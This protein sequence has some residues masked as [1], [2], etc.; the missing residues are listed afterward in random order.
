MS[1]FYICPMHPKVRQIG[2]GDC[3]ICGM[4]LELE[5]FSKNATEV[6]ENIELIDFK[7]RFWISLILSFPII[8]LSMGEHLVNFSTVI[9]PNI[10]RYIQLIFSLPVVLWGGFPFFKRGWQSVQSYHLN[11][12][13]L[14]SLGTG[15]ALLYSAIATCFPTLFP[16]HLYTGTAIPVY[17]EVASMLVVLVLL[18]QMLEIKAREKTGHAIKA[19]LDLT[20]FV[21]HRIYANQEEDIALDKVQ[22]NDKLRVKPGEK[23]PVDGRV[24]EGESLVDESMLTGEPMPVLKVVDNAVIA[25]TVNGSGVL[26]IEAEKLTQDTLLSQII[27]LVGKAQRSHAPIQRLADIVSGYFVPIVIL[28]AMLA[29]IS[30]FVFSPSEG[31]SRGILAFVSVLIIACPCALGL[32]TPMSIMVGVGRG[33]RRGILIKN[34]EALELLEKVNTIIFDKTGTLTAGHPTLAE[35][36]PFGDFDENT[37]LQMA[38]ALEQSSEHPLANAIKIEA[39]RRALAP[40]VVQDIEIVPGKGVVGH[41]NGQV[42]ALGNELQMQALNV[43]I[44]A[45]E[46]KANALREQGA[47]IIYLSTNQVLAGIMAVLDAVKP[48]TAGALHALKQYHLNCVMLTG[49]NLKTAKTVAALL[50]IDNIYAGVLPAEKHQI[51][52]SYQAKGQI[53]AM[54][55]DGINDAPALATA[56]V[57]IAM[58]TGTDVAMESAAVTLL[59]GDL[60]H[61]VESVHLSHAVMKNIRQNLFFAFFYNALGVPLAAGVFYPWFG[62]QL[63]PLIAALAMSFS[64]LSV[65]L[66]AL[67]LNKQVL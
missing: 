67:R 22:L 3:P 5:S 1:S 25:G 46:E 2:P 8:F 38:N 14:I 10:S 61:L 12:F 27:D 35:V 37:V 23:I 6:T 13:T 63:S 44:L 15:V 24:L 26:I 39:K 36:I 42:I 47:T 64:S 18:G 17:F 54:V 60:S 52:Q 65:V 43:N 50:E 34:A 41:M 30:W 45:A 53:V 56:D 51:I 29:L 11:M 19:L 57:G 9:S 21:A 16:A 58:G 48:T 7:R 4:A 33:A 55:G 32:A 59:S 40:L 28:V 62:L 66:N 31:L 49:D 20:P